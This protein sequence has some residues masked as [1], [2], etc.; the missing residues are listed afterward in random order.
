MDAIVDTNG[1][2]V[3]NKC[4]IITGE[5]IE[6]LCSFFN[7][8]VFSV[9]LKQVNTT[10]GKGPEFI[11]NIKAIKPTGVDRAMTDEEICKLYSLSDEEIRVIS[12]SVSP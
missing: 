11:K 2:F 4:Y 6:F 10:G 3:N 12:A 1:Y 5:Y 9:I 8:S 7:S